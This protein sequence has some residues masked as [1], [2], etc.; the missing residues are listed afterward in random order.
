MGRSLNAPNKASADFVHILEPR[1]C[2][3]YDYP[4]LDRSAVVARPLV[5]QSMDH[6]RPS[7]IDRPRAANH[8]RSIGAKLLEW[9]TLIFIRET[10]SLKV[11]FKKDP[12][13]MLRT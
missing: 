6:G 11:V 5:D 8:G 9:L 10:F 1:N 3:C 7:A 2:I 12:E 4:S 13:S